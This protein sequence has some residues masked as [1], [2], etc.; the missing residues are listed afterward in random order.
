MFARRP[1]AGLL[2]VVASAILAAGCA[3]APRAASSPEPKAPAVRDAEQPATRA[4]AP[5]EPDCVPGPGSGSGSSSTSDDD[6]DPGHTVDDGFEA[7][8]AEHDAKTPLPFADLDDAQLTAKLSK[9]IGALGPM[10]I[11]HA[12]GGVL[13]A[14][15][16]MPAGANWELVSPSL[17]WGTQET[18]DALAHAID[19]VAAK[20]P[21][22]PKAFI[23]NISGKYG[24]HLPP[25]VS[26]QS[27]R[28]VDLGYYHLEGHHRWYATATSAN[29]DRARTWHLVRTLIADSDVDLVLMD[30]GVQRIMKAY[31]RE[32]GEDPAWLDQIFQVGGKSSRPVIFHAKGHATHLH[33]RFYSPAAQ[34][35]G[36][37]AYRMLLARR[38]ITPP[39]SF[40]THTTKQGDT[41]SHLAVRYKVSAE[42]I[43][44]A[45]GM[46]GDVLRVAKQIKIPQTGGVPVPARLA[47]PARR[48][49]PPL[50][51]AERSTP[52]RTWDGEP[53]KRAAVAEGTRPGG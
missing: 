43:K 20:F 31:A 47:L 38:L 18:V 16:Q 15:V 34:E 8:A 7:P 30:L 11:G 52:G 6:A 22:T 4:P 32:I 40:I 26:H 23:G 17:S 36:R 1:F 24:G 5:A 33:V 14:G 25:H 2:C 29:L 35:L 27:G 19:A 10:S 53:C 9:D 49:P 3:G 21:S 41:L 13:V 50:M 45:N 12:H 42:A 44:K 28:D 48:V 39:T 46:H 51:T 37:R